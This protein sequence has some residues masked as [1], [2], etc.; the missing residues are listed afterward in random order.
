MNQSVSQ[1]VANFEFKLPLYYVVGLTLICSFA[2]G[3]T[4]IFVLWLLPD[5][6]PQHTGVAAGL[7]MQL[8]FL[9]G[10]LRSYQKY[11]RRQ[12]FTAMALTRPRH[13]LPLMALALFCF[14]VEL[15]LFQFIE[16]SEQDFQWMAD[17]IGSLPLWLSLLTVVLLAPL[18]EELFFRQMFW[19]G[20]REQF[21]SPLIATLISSALWALIHTQYS[22][23]GVSTL[24][25]YGILLGYL[26]HKSSSVIPCI[27]LHSAINALALA[28][29]HLG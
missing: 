20:L 3:L 16:P 24:F 10:M 7:A 17:T 29:L 28:E 8:T 21:H 9:A 15:L 12:M 6:V 19:A 14:G 2:S 1:G 25:L 27:L 23:Q 26:R 11:Y 22:F 13:F 4:Y 18:V 5:N